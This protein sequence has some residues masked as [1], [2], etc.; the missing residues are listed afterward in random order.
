MYGWR[1]MP[2][3]RRQHPRSAASGSVSVRFED[4]LLTTIEAEMLE[5]S[6]SGFRIAHDCER[7]RS[8]LEIELLRGESGDRARVI[9]THNQ[10]GRRV[11]GC[12]LL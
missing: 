12:L 8:G 2:I 10:D 6:E 4:P 7:L 5:T 9:W 11:S 1:A 3:E